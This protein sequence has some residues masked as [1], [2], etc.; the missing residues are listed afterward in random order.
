[1]DDLENKDSW[2]GGFAERQTARKS[3]WHATKPFLLGAL[4]ALTIFLLVRPLSW[5]L[6]SEF[7]AIHPAA[8]ISLD[9]FLRIQG[10]GMLLAMLPWFIPIVGLCMLVGNGIYWLIPYARNAFEAEAGIV[11]SLGFGPALRASALTLLGGLV[12]ATLLS[13]LGLVF[14][15]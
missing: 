3:A 6:W 12:F 5:V 13:S 10:P 8:N 14:L 1:M 11:H 4:L 15:H 9:Q 7:R 2:L